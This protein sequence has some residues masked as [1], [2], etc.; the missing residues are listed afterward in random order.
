M[1]SVAELARAV[2]PSASAP[3]PDAPAGRPDE[4]QVAW[5]RVL[6]A[7]VPAL[8]ALE[9]DDLVV[10][11]EG[12]LRSVAHDPAEARTL[13]EDLARSA[14]AALLFVGDVGA[15]DAVATAAIEAC[16][17]RVFAYRLAAGEPAAL[18]RAAIGFL[19][20]QRAE[21]ERQASRLEA[22]L[23]ALS[24]GGGGLDEMAAAI[25]GFLAR[26]VAIEG[27]RGEALA[28]HAP[29]DLAGAAGAVARY[30][31]QP[32]GVALRTVLPGSPGE[33]AG[34]LA[35]LGEE[36]ASE[37][38][39]VASERVAV[40]LALELTRD[41]ALLRARDALRRG[42]AL[43]AAGPPWVVLMAR[44]G[45]GDDDSIEARERRREAVRRLAPASRLGLRGD[46]ASL[47]LRLVAA[48]ARSDP[49]GLDLAAR[50]TGLLGRPVAVSR[51]FANP[52]GRPSAEAEA[53]ATLEAGEALGASA[54]IAAGEIRRPSVS[55]FRADR[56]PA[57]RLLGS[58]TTL[59]DGL[60]HARSLLEPLLVGRAETRRRRLETLE[61]ALLHPNLAQAAT[62]LGIHRNTLAYR[63]GRI[64]ART[65]WS[66]DDPELRLALALAVRI[67][68]KD[69][70]ETAGGAG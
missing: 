43:P 54:S 69:E 15:P 67:V 53:R 14:V 1:P 40:H 16:L 68:H 30:H 6:R 61:A 70:E 64:E 58:L 22:E 17:G 35:L 66:L 45:G 60:R 38:E 33:A 28:V 25:A 50:L 10:V 39:R 42:E 31:A 11:P 34:S 59:P 51:T 36:P 8:D 21:V 52:E 19:V 57:Y 32:R 24:L 3:L 63:L 37:L 65:G 4:R 29:A 7:R 5:V 56:L 48:P 26:A 2:F 46:A 41:A 20:N 13:V 23:Q 44:Q 62:A 9:R 27:A 18:E 55:A 49:F 47:E 12:A